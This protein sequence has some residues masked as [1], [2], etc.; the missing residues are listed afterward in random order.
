ME[1]KDRISEL[2]KEISPTLVKIRRHIHKNPELAFNEFET[3]NYLKSW[4]EKANIEIRTDYSETGIVGLL[5]GNREN[6]VVAL[7]GDIDALPLY[8]E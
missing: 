8:E 6:P 2:S 5:K 3:T 7:R 4:L 1:M